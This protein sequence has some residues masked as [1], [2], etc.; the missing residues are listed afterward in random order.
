MGSAQSIAISYD[1]E[2][3]SKAGL[4]LNYNRG[5]FMIKPHFSKLWQSF[6]DHNKYPT[7]EAL[8]TSLGGTAAKNIKSP[9][10]GPKGNTC[11][12]RMSI[13]FNKA[14]APIDATIA[15]AVGARTLGTAD[16]SRIIF[17]VIEF[18]KY[19]IKLLGKPLTDVKSPYDDVFRGRKGIIVFSVNWGDASGHAAL[20]NGATYR[21]PTH[22]NYSTYV[23]PE[24]PNVRTSLGEFWE[25]QF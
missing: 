1:E 18:R 23:N 19:L 10:F 4:A 17:S 15:H 12:S 2:S 14:G 5:K 20:W 7:L 9:G 21:E 16:G 25:L 22:D 24:V 11:A 8:Y 3:I 6:P 13:A